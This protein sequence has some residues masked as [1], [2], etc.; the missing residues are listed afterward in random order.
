MSLL[1]THYYAPQVVPPCWQVAGSG[2]FAMFEA[3][4]K[5]AHTGSRMRVAGL[6]GLILV[7]LI[8]LL[9]TPPCEEVAD[10]QAGWISAVT[11][12]AI[13]FL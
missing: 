10:L 1:V 7:P 4:I 13:V 12:S 3:L 5:A 11:K 9:G 6:S 8:G 2:V